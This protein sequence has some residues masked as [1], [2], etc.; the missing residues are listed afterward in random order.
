MTSGR[1][2]KRGNAVVG[3]TQ[4]S[5]HLSGDAVDYVPA[6]GQSMAQLEAQARSYFG[7]NV[8]ILNEG[9]HIHVAYP[10]GYGRVPYYGNRGAQ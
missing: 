8:K 2:T 10:R 3:G 4:N 1:R 6:Q 5:R 9:D 7:P